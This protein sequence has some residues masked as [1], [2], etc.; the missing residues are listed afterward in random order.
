MYAENPH[1]LVEGLD[2][3]VER[4]DAQGLIREVRKAVIAMA[5]NCNQQKREELVS[6]LEELTEILRACTER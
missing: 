5:I 6:G 4:G 1:T 3:F 2:D